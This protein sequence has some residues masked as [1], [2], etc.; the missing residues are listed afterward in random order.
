MEA[1]N[2]LLF[3]YND[4][5]DVYL[6]FDISSPKEFFCKYLSVAFGRQMFKAVPSKNEPKVELSIISKSGI[7]ISLQV[8]PL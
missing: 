1:N 8:G 2:R 3:K 4:Y 7:S 5:K 6:A